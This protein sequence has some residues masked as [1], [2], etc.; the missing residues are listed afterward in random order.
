MMSNSAAFCHWIAYDRSR[1][2][3][4]IEA[5]TVRPCFCSDVLFLLFAQLF[6]FADVKAFENA[7]MNA[8]KA[9]YARGIVHLHQFLC[10]ALYEW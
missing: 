7:I 6:F 3:S 4:T 9:D 8:L 5:F 10:L 1:I 2:V